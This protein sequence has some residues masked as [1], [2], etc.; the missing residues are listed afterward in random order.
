MILILC[1]C[2]YKLNNT[3]ELF[4]KPMENKKTACLNII[5]MVTIF[6]LCSCSFVA[7][8]NSEFKPSGNLWGLMFGDYYY[9]AHSDSLGRGAGNVQYKPFSLTSTLNAITNVTAS[10]TTTAS[11]DI[12]KLTIATTK[13]NILGSGTNNFTSANAFQIRRFYLG[14][15]YQ[16]TP[17]LT[18]YALLSDEQDL[19][20]SGNNTVYLKYAYLKWN[21]IFHGN[22]LLIGQQATPAFSFI[23]YSIGTLWGY[24]SVERTIS[25]MHNNESSNDLGIALEGLLWKN[26]SPD[27][28]NHNLIGYFLMLGNGNSAK[29]END[30]YKNVM[31]LLYTSLFQQKLTL[32]FYWDYH[33][34]SLSPLN[35]TVHTYKGFL[36]FKISKFNI[37]TEIFTQDW[38]NSNQLSTGVWR[39]CQ[40]FGWSGFITGKILQNLN[41]YTRLDIYNPD[42]RFHNH[43]IY[44]S[45]PSIILPSYTQVQTV[46]TSLSPFSLTASPV[47]QSVVF[48][49]Q[50]FYLI[51]L[52][53]TPDKRFHIMPNLWADE[54]TSLVNLPQS[55]KHARNDCDIV[56]RI[57]FYFIFNSVNK[58]YNNGMDN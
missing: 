32:G 36:D 34:A 29:P 23:P 33:I 15:D 38:T 13:S 30:G 27:T 16:F 5:V 26:T 14:Y 41:F 19:D 18:A 3:P 9:M 44:T 49:R 58:V 22:N 42:L 24:R 54:F 55:A 11:G 10:A 1:L 21:N 48:S 17:K 25:D 39:D 56:P 35:Q 45:V 40:I 4:L 52:D 6:Y 46:T 12:T 37:G 50:T 2:N 43:N 31:F 57:T 7:A 53:Y 20:A 47:N 51:G 8:Q 28:L